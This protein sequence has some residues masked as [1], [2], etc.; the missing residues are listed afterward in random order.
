MLAVLRGRDR[1]SPADGPLHVEA[2]APEVDIRPHQ[3]RRPAPPKSREYTGQ[4]ER[5]LYLG[6]AG[7]RSHPLTRGGSGEFREWLLRRLWSYGLIL[8]VGLGPALAH[9]S[10]K[11]SGALAWGVA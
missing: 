8:L 7:G 11:I 9:W 5:R 4:D 10:S 1:A 2:T 3:R 6:E